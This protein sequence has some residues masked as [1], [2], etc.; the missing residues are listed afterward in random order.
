MRQAFDGRLISSNADVN[1][2]PRTCDL[3]PLAHFLWGAIKGKYYDHKPETIGH[4]KS[5]ISDPIADIRHHT[6][7]KV[8]E[9]WSN[10][11]KITAEAAAA[12]I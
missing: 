9:N 4:L 5:N 3:T 10:G 2:P 11:M 8:H 1:W 12:V 6:L 7:E